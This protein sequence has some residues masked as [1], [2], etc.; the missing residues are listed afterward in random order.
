[1]LEYTLSLPITSSLHSKY[2]QFIPV[3]EQNGFSNAIKVPP[4]FILPS[5][6]DRLLAL[7]R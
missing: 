6:S 3:K 5:I 4:H 2:Q 1:M 7:R